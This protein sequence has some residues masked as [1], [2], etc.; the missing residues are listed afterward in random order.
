VME[1]FSTGMKLRIAALGEDA[2]LAGSLL[3]A[4]RGSTDR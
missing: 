1:V 3:L 4:E 2:V